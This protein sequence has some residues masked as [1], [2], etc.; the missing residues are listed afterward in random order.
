MSKTVRWTSILIRAG[1]AL[2]MACAAALP[3]TAQTLEEAI[4]DLVSAHP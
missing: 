3:A 2:A 1:T 4:I